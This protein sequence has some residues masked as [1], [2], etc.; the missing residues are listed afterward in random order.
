LLS[1]TD[2]VLETQR[3][4]AEVIIINNQIEQKPV[5]EI[6]KNKSSNSDLVFL[7]IPPIIEGKEDRF[8]D[9]VIKLCLDNTSVVFV[10]ASSYFKEL[11]I[12][13]ETKN[14]IHDIRLGQ[15][16]NLII[17]NKS[18]IPELPLPEK[19]ILRE[20]ISKLNTN[21]VKVNNSFYDSFLHKL[22]EFHE[23]TIDALSVSAL[24]SF[25]QIRQQGSE[26][27]ALVLQQN[28]I[29]FHNSY[30]FGTQKVLDDF[31]KNIFN[32]QKDLI[33]E[34]IVFLKNSIEKLINSLPEYLEI[35][36]SEEELKISKN[37]SFS[38]K[39]FKLSKQLKR[40]FSNLLNV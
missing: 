7:G 9:D 14:I 28:I 21:L 23:K 26:G 18:D 3:I 22:F 17:K 12:G 11:Q 40:I 36:Y 24:E 2:K 32:T 34:G 29:K 5:H 39:T 8:S 37:D 25:K 15:E 16:N 30:L 35:E 19:I 1:D 33:S 4:S 10:N 27:S 31:E 6:I 13:I 38:L 20:Q